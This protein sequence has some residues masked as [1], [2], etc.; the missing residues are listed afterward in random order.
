[1]K[2]NF[3]ETFFIQP[4]EITGDYYLF[5]FGQNHELIHFNHK[6]NILEE[7]P[8]EWMESLIK[9]NDYNKRS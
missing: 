2:Y 9:T 3:N 6:K 5:T 7:M 8:Q 4:N 1:M